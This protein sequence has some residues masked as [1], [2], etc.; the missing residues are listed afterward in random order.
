MLEE[1]AHD[2]FQGRVRGSDPMSKAVNPRLYSVVDF[3]TG[4]LLNTTYNQ[5]IH[6]FGSEISVGIK[7]SKFLFFILNIYCY[8]NIV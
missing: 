8:R 2:L 5:I 3:M 4:G 1:F 7:D 6:D